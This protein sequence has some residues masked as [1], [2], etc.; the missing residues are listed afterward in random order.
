MKVLALIG[1]ILAG[2]SADTTPTPEYTSTLT[3]EEMHADLTAKYITGPMMDRKDGCG[4][5]TEEYEPCSSGCVTFRLSNCA[6]DDGSDPP[7]NCVAMSECEAA[8]AGGLIIGLIIGGILLIV[9]II[10]LLNCF[11]CPEKEEGDNKDN[12]NRV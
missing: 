5:Y 11:L 12:Y 10:G 6:Y 3:Y 8:G 7:I 4:T 9:L 1:A 2:A